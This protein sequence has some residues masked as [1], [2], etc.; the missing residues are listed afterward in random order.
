VELPKRLIELYTYFEDV[1][2]DPFMGAG[3]TAVAA[4][5]TGRHY[6]GFET[7]AAYCK[8]SEERIADERAR[9]VSEDQPFRVHLPAVGPAN[10]AEDF[11]SRAVREGRQARKLAG[12]LLTECGFL[13]VRVNVK[14][15]R[16]GIEVDFVAEDHRGGEW[17]FDV[18]GAFTSSRPGL[19]R[20]DTLWKALGKAAVL[21]QAPDEQAPTVV[22]LTTNAPTP[23]SAGATALQVMR[24]PGRPIFDVIELLDRAGQQKL[25]DYALHGRPDR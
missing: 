7:D 20:T 25:R 5:R 21:S 2:L 6:L 9:L 22:L 13:N 11:Q 14:F 4:I 18:S 16:L 17:A 10:E 8:R 1:V 24:G 19:K 15:R 23:G 3:T 12:L